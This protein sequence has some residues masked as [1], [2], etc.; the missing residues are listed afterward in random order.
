MSWYINSN[1]IFSI[2]GTKPTLTLLTLDF[3][4]NA[5]LNFANSC[6]L[7][8]WLTWTFLTLNFFLMAKLNFPFYNT[9]NSNSKVQLFSISDGQWWNQQ[10]Q[11]NAP[12][13]LAILM[14]T[15]VRRGYTDSITQCTMSRATTEATDC[16]HWATTCSVLPRRLPR[17]AIDPFVQARDMAQWEEEEERADHNLRKVPF[18]RRKKGLHSSTNMDFMRC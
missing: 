13:L 16:C 4:I 15:A 9:S 1:S 12:L 14:A 10:W 3:K 11:M 5:T 8:K 6:F 2:L 7:E 17:H 18:K